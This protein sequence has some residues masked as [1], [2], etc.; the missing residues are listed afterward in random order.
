[1]SVSLIVIGSLNADIVATGLKRFPKPG[2]HVY[3]KE[4]VIGPGGKSRNI[5]DM[6]A[7]L[8][9]TD[10]V[11]MLGR[12]AKDPYGFW[13]VPIEALQKSSVNTDFIVIDEATDKLPAIAL[14]AVDDNGNNQI[15][16]LPGASDDFNSEDIDKADALFAEVAKNNGYIAITL[17]C[18]LETVRY[19]VQKVKGL[20][21]WA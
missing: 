4:L 7:H 5:A 2:E 18:P 3:G 15:I 20:G 10:T 12:T 1:M 19:A 9:E 16:V 11:A 17:E 14:I 21:T 8:M 13:K 6:A